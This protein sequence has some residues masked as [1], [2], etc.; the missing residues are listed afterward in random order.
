MSKSLPPVQARC[1]EV[2]SAANCSYCQLA[3]SLL[4]DRGLTFVERDIS[5]PGNKAELLVR[6]PRARSIPQIFVADVHIGGYDD[7]CLH[8]ASGSLEIATAGS[9]PEGSS[10]MHQHKDEQ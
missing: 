10:P 4:R 9:G 3:K 7:L 1:I 5:D 8:L 6:L 2:F